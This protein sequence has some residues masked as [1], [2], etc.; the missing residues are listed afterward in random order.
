MDNTTTMKVLA[1]LLLLCLPPGSAQSF[2]VCGECHCLVA[3]GETCPLQPETNF[4]QQVETLRS[5]VWENPISLPCNP[6]TNSSCETVPARQDGQVCAIQYGYDDSSSPSCPTRYTLESMASREQAEAEGKIVTHEG[7]CAACSSLQDLAVYM[8]F[9]D[10]QQ[11]GRVCGIKTLSSEEEA[12][13]CYQDLGFSEACAAIWLYNTIRS[14]APQAQSGCLEPCLQMTLGLLP[15]FGPPPTCDLHPCIQCDEDVSGPIFKEY[16]GRTRRNSGILG[17]IIRPCDS[18]AS[19]EHVDPCLV[20]TTTTEDQGS[21]T[22]TSTAPAA[23]SSRFQM[24]LASLA[25]I[26][27][28]MTAYS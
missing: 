6:Y 3:N 16:A 7:P 12:L 17:N 25:V 22:A 15:A 18:I 13:Q 2:A 20:S 4:T 11:E 9:P 26:V 27:I 19:I 24:I 1:P 8:E 10:L 21:T 5:L 23:W 14:R 28:F